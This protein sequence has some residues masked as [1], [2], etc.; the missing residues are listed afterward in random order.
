MTERIFFDWK[1]ALLP[2]AAKWL[3]T[4]YS[5]HEL[6]DMRRH[7]LVFPGQRAL[8]RCRELL[9]EEAESR[10]LL[11]VP[12]R[13]T[14]V[15]MLPEL[16]AGI[17]YD[18]ASETQCLY[19][20][21]DA[22]KSLK[23]QTLQILLPVFP[24]SSDSISWLMLAERIHSIYEEISGAVLTFQDVALRTQEVSSFS[25]GTRW[26]VLAQLYDKYCEKLSQHGLSDCH[27]L[28]ISAL[29]KESYSLSGDLI[30][31]SAAD[32]SEL[33]KT[34]LRKVRSPLISIVHAPES[35]LDDFDEIGCINIAKWIDARLPLKEEQYSIVEKPVD[36]AK[37]V[38][39]KIGDLQGS[40]SI[41]ALKIGICD[42]SLSPY[43]I[44]A[45]QEKGIPIRD[46]AGIKASNFNIFVFLRTL[47]DFLASRRFSSFCSLFRIPELE[48]W[49]RNYFNTE[50]KPQFAEL[51]YI[52]ILDEYQTIYLQAE[53]GQ[54]VFG[55]GE[56]A[57]IVAILHQ[58]LAV[59]IGDFSGA[60]QSIRAWAQSLMRLLLRLYEGI[61]IPNEGSEREIFFEQLNALHALAEELYS[62]KGDDISINGAEALS[63]FLYHLRSVSIRVD[64]SSPALETLGWLELRLD[65]APNLFITGFNEMFVP[66][67]LISDPF[68][69]D[70]TRHFLGLLDNDK[71]YARDAYALCTML[72]SKKEI[73]LIGARQNAKRE[74]L[75]P[76][77]LLYTG[78]PEE[79]AKRV[80]QIFDNKSFSSPLRKNKIN[81]Q[82]I[83]HLPERP[84]TMPQALKTLSVSGFGD[85]L[86]CPYRFYLRHVLKL[87][88]LD[89]SMLEL[90][91][92]C[93][94][95]FAHDI[96][97]GFG[98]SSLRN[99]ESASEIGEFL[100]T[101]LSAEAGKRFGS[102][103]LP[104]VLVQLE[105]LKGRFQIFASWQ[106]EWRKAG[107]EIKDVEVAFKGSDFVLNEK[108][109]VLQVTGRID[110][111][112]YNPRLKRYLIFDY[113]TGDS[114][115]TPEQTHRKRKNWVDLQLP[116]YHYYFKKIC[117]V[118]EPVDLGLISICAN[119]EQI[120]EEIAAWSEDEMNE[121][122][123]RMHDVARKVLEQNFWPPANIPARWDDFAALC[124]TGQLQ[125]RL[126]E[127]ED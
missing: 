68:L 39:K 97:N 86:Q 41:S 13:M 22:L 109:G 48:E 27:M 34:F 55:E 1:Q 15:G 38:V 59:L 67:V 99:S 79:I 88:P 125:Q 10:K 102:R 35:R 21:I 116:M 28:R 96:L 117:G 20:W 9:L 62:I 45:V 123:E 107:W 98:S 118:R 37:L 53:I 24:D 73:V 57:R 82:K 60:L 5:K 2:R 126:L 33:N 11:L 42:P 69:P 51:D 89:D 43:L 78:S 7:T 93:F 108:N 64:P 4:R 110:R 120:G 124:G 6:C 16:I 40:V 56:Y 76:S 80:E 112:D 122:Y 104:A 77:R 100:S 18:T 113:K 3:V 114:K 49:I 84:R 127:T 106:A 8:R 17:S 87:A 103:V 14:S 26:E 91:P 115:S 61:K 19:A 119:S 30:L 46:A 101:F 90:D 71:R 105:Q 47:K 58:A 81:R 25:D 29:Q 63:H 74:R 92:F 66:E 85:Y 65:D 54:A 23:R 52:S 50:G 95:G 94:G 44:Q 12:P 31:V 36:V 121:A 75:L 83:F 32:L 111:I 70:S 72:Y